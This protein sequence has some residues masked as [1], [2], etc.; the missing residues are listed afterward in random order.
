MDRLN[1]MVVLFGGGS[2]MIISGLICLAVLPGSFFDIPGSWVS[3]AHFFL[4]Q[5]I[6]T[7]IWA[8]SLPTT[9]R[10]GAVAA[11]LTAMFIYPLYIVATALLIILTFSLSQNMMSVL[12]LI[13][14]GLVLLTSAA[15]FIAGRIGQS[16][17]GLTEAEA[18]SFK[19]LQNAIQSS[20]SA[21][22]LNPV[23]KR[24]TAVGSRLDELADQ[25]NYADKKSTDE[26]LQMEHQIITKLS[27][28]ANAL[29][30]NSNPDEQMLCNQLDAIKELILARHQ[31]ILQN[32]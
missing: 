5:I 18:A 23:G 16:A 9:R 7:G 26:T 1:R 8:F 20:Q 31:H 11:S 2:L 17:D 27:E 29:T 24:L 6:T 14:F 22:R 4:A 10:S 12:H 15:L 21:F 3:L 28:V 19:A 25:I 13:L 30:Q 32:K